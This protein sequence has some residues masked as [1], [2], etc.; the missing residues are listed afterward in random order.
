MQGSID[1]T[2]STHYSLAKNFSLKNI[3]QQGSLEFAE[4]PK[5]ENSRDPR[6]FSSKNPTKFGQRLVYG[7]LYVERF[8]RGDSNIPRFA[9]EKI[10]N[11]FVIIFTFATIW[12]FFFIQNH[13][14]IFIK[15]DFITL[16]YQLSKPGT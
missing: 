14:F 3:S 15:T 1:N 4:Y 10:P 12:L 6:E 7:D 9:H 2:K 11:L 16:L 8:A 5:F 13:T